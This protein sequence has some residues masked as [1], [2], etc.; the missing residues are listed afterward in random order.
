MPTE[1]LTTDDRPI[2]AF[3]FALLGGLLMIA[4]GPEMYAMMQRGMDGWSN[5]G[6]HMAG[7]WMN[8]HG[9]FCNLMPG[10]AS[11]YMPGHLWPWMT[12][13][14]GG[15]I[16][17]AA[18]VI[19]ARPESRGGWGITI[20]VAATAALLVGSGGLLAAALAITGGILALTWKPA[21][22]SAGASHSTQ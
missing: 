5:P 2:P 10:Y 22:T 15:L 19:L 21:S 16:L 11:G 18:I 6:G 20:I 9:L 17:V 14:A 12:L 8:N 4:S 1:T 7:R 13:L 3:V